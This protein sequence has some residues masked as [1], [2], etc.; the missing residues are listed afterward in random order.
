MNGRA[1]YRDQSV[2]VYVTPAGEDQV[3]VAASVVD[4]SCD[5]AQACA[6]AYRRIAEV[7]TQARMEIVHE[8]LFG[9]VCVQSAV[10]E[11]RA[12]AMRQG[13]ANPEGPVTYIEGHPLWGEGFAGALLHGVRPSGPSEDVWTLYEGG[14]PCG[15]GWRRDGATFLI[16]QSIHGLDEGPSSENGRVAQARRMF[17]RAEKILRSHG[18]TYQDV[19]RTWI[20]LS[21]IL[22]WY[23]E[24]NETR[25]AK[26]EEFGIMPGP[27]TEPTDGP[28]RLPASTGIRGDNP[29]GAA[30][31]A[32]VL[33]L[34]PGPGPGPEVARMT[35]MKQKEAFMYGSAFSRG[36]CIRERDVTHIHISGTAAIDERGAT[37]FPGDARAQIG[38]TF[39]IVEALLTQEGASLKDLCDVSVFLK[40]PED[41][42]IYHRTAAERGLADMPVVCA[43]ADT[44]RDDLLF[45]MDASAIVSPR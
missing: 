38:R 17:E 39:D 12:E 23:D 27:S 15:R 26:Y 44:C 24:F 40:R 3:Y 1:I 2:T 19:V 28:L 30:A 6:E 10:V 4:G 41:A 16:L 43:M 18:A 5:P 11:A 8:R 32:D 36:T 20:Y 29:L 45:E 14:S 35:N 33:A 42:A 34:I 25:N 9:N 13:G 7:F 31:V 22:D 37:L 21:D